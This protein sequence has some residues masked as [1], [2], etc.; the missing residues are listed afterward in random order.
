MASLPTPTTRYVCADVIDGLRALPPA[1]VHAVLTSPPYY[2]LRTYADVGPTTWADGL[3][4]TYGLEATLEEYVAHTVEVFREV[5]RVL[6][7]D[8]SFWL[9]IGDGYAGG[10]AH[11]EPIKYAAAD[12]S[13]PSR[14]RQRRLSSK[15]L[16]LI[17]ARVALALQADGW[18]LRQDNI[19]AKGV[20]FCSA[21]SGSVMPE[22]TRDRT[23]WAHEHVFH[24][25]LTEGA[26]YDQD[27][28]REP[29]ADSTLRSVRE[30][31]RGV[32]LK[33][34]GAMGVQ[35]PSDTKRRV[36]AS[37][38][39]GAGRNLRNVWIIPK[40]PFAGGHF[41]TFPEALVDP[42]IRLATSERGVCHVCGSPYRRKTLREA[43]PAVVTEA[44][45][46]ARGES[47]A[48]TGRTDGH[49]Q[50]R[51]NFRRRVIRTEWEPGC[52]C[53]VDSSRVAATVLDPFCGGSG[54]AARVASRLG[55][56]FI[57]IDASRSYIAM[58]VAADPS[59]AADDVRPADAQQRGAA[60]AGVS[61]AAADACAGGDAVR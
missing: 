36:L 10:G 27:G 38:A 20:S 12:S 55:R 32:G 30:G 17:P 16:M 9:N 37:V 57:G 43:V 47:A 39:A 41:A 33:P 44:F 61:D 3:I 58:A 50:R 54:R 13:K 4:A 8:G 6:R 5:K 45:E 26:F 28:C 48:R 56:S 53:A 60:V 34:Y 25:T 59:D 21:Y 14:A 51:P 18:I 23:T 11:A 7:P 1:S 49:T 46:R 52:A 31:Y 42:I 2:G 22:S 29:Y 19:W 15:D 35:N 40:Q 24:F